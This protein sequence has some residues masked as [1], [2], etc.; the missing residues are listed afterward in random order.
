MKLFIAQLVN[1]G[2]VPH[3]TA[4]NNTIQTGLNVL[5]GIIGAVGV[6]L[7]VI[8]GLRYMLAGG[9]ANRVEESKRMI[10]YTLVGM[11][12]VA[13]AATIVEFVLKAKP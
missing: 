3:A 11:A 8:A 10:A 9:D 1:G 13:L 7:L 2:S 4:D 12:V 5:Y 6:L